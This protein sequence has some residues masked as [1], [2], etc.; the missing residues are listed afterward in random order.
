[1]QDMGAGLEGD[2]VGGRIVTSGRLRG[3]IFKGA[4]DFTLQLIHVEVPYRHE[5]HALGAIPRVVV[6]D[7]FVATGDGQHLLGANGQAMGDARVTVEK[8]ELGEERAPL[9]GITGAF[10]AEDDASLAVD[11]FL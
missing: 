9:H 11:F 7:K 3:E 2:G 5:G 4:N 6:V 1:M 10:F 8:I